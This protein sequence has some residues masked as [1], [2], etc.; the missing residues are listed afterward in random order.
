MKRLKV[1]SPPVPPPHTHEHTRTHSVLNSSS[2]CLPV[3]ETSVVDT[4]AGSGVEEEPTGGLN[5]IEQ[6]LKG[7]SDPPVFFYPQRKIPPHHRQRRRVWIPS[8]SWS[9]WAWCCWSSPWLSLVFLSTASATGKRDRKVGR[10][11]QTPTES[12]TRTLFWCEDHIFC[13]YQ[14]QLS[15]L[16]HQYLSGLKEEDPYLDGSP[17]EK[18]P[19]W[20]LI[21]CSDDCFY[22][23]LS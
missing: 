9:L 4:E 20:V 11:Q 17:T 10:S 14:Q 8:S 19:M 3:D 13:F 15:L 7:T 1:L 18:V 6:D 23:P 5:G 2:D 12:W 21:S 22:F 16:N